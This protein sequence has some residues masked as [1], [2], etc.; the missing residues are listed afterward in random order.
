LSRSGKWVHI[1]LSGQEILSFWR[2]YRYP[3]CERGPSRWSDG[4]SLE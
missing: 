4:N 3:L 2:A 1:W